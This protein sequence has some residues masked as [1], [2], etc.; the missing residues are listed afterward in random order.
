MDVESSEE[1]KDYNT[2]D[3]MGV[4]MVAF[5]D[6][7]IV[8]G[9]QLSHQFPLGV[10]FSPFSSQFLAD[11]SLPDGA[12]LHQTDQSYIIME[13]EDSPIKYGIAFFRNKSDKSASRGAIQKALL[14][15]S[16]YPHF[17]LFEQVAYEVIEVSMTLPQTEMDE[18]LFK[19]YNALKIKPEKVITT[20]GLDKASHHVE[21]CVFDYKHKLSVPATYSPLQ[22]N[23]TSLKFLLSRLKVGLILF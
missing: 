4:E 13:T 2:D 8:N 16:K 3:I 11:C 9:T 21:V 14:V 17:H 19:L 7:D 10:E 23:G 1:E 5:I 20:T 22:Y 15:I 12:H 18:L 6:F